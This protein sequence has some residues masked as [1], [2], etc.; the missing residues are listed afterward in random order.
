MVAFFFSAVSL[1]RLL[2]EEF[3]SRLLGPTNLSQLFRR[4]LTEEF[5]SRLLGPTILLFSPFR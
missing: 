4:L 1:R 3:G 2:T 5:E